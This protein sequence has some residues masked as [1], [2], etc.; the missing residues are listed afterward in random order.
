MSNTE[1]STVTDRLRAMSRDGSSIEAAQVKVIGLDEIREAAGTRWPRM[2]E[3]VQSGSHAILSRHCG[4]DDVIIPAG[5]GFLIMLAEGR[6]GDT[7]RRCQEM[8]DALLAFYLGEDAFSALRPEVKNRSLT[9]DAVNELISTSTHESTAPIV[10]RSH[11]EDIAFA[12]L[13]LARESRV[14]AL[15]AAPVQRAAGGRRIIYNPEFIL[16]GRHHE[17]RDY[18][19]LDIAVLDAALTRMAHTDVP[20]GVTVHSTVL[21]SRRSREV[22]FNW[23]GGLESDVRKRLFVGIS[24][25]ERG[26]PLI[27]ITEWCA[28]LRRLVAQVSLGFHY[29]D[30]AISS[31]GAAGAWSA[32]FHLPGFAGAQQTARADKMREHIRFWSRSVRGQGMRLVVHGFQNAA[33][34][35]EAATLG[36]DMLT[37][38]AHWP[39]CSL[40]A[41]TADAAHA[42]AGMLAAAAPI[43]ATRTVN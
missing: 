11:G 16:D 35:D 32:G 4:P 5:D 14:G 31:V 7:Q 22:Y 33:F 42:D 6:P 13:L 25:I 38:D 29:T 1:L 12:P 39:F 18:L 28:T 9:T 8:R 23:L 43:S 19:E 24:E 40:A 20:M 15:L 27:S 17:R 37:S 30:H 10:A 41:Y 34:L 36:V 2:R 3:R 26:T 21:Q